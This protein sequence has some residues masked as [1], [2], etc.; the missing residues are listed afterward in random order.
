MQRKTMLLIYN[1]TSGQ[2]LFPQ[3]LSEVVNQFTKNG[4]LVTVYPTQAP[5]DAYH[6]TLEYSAGYDYLVCSG[7][8]GTLNET[9]DALMQLGRR[10]TFGY[11]P[12]GTTNDFAASLGIPKDV[13][14]AAGVVTHGEARPFDI[15]RFGDEYF[16]YVAAFGLFTDVSYGTS[17][18]MKNA[19]G[20][21]A[22]LLEGAKRLA[23]IRSYACTFKLGTEK[24]TGKF[25]F[26]MVTNSLSVGGFRIHREGSVVQMDDGLFEVLLLRKPRSFID[27]QNVIA[28]ILNQE[29][30]TDSLIIRKVSELTVVSE[31]P[32]SWTLD[33]EFGGEL[34]EV[35][36]QN[37][38]N[39][40][41]IMMPRAEGEG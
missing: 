19:L 4:F 40:I 18:G 23:S 33:G 36:I 31:E 38:H 22:Y 26:G 29:I 17:Q 14:E 1:P 27:L 9:I 24:I 15:G 8:D 6:M 13:L 20:H 28:S 2:Q 16:S 34:A 3:N 10:P 21:L 39:A 5:R 37:L 41:E 7:G 30:Y 12:S 11:L 35:R 32:L 25:I